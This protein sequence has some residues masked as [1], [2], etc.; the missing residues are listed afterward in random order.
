MSASLVLR[1]E[2][3]WDGCA[4]SPSSYFTTSTETFSRV[5]FGGARL[6]RRDLCLSFANGVADGFP[7]R[8]GGAGVVGQQRGKF[9]GQRGGGGHFPIQGVRLMPLSFLSCPPPSSSLPIPGEHL[10]LLRLPRA[11]LGLSLPYL[12]RHIIR[13]ILPSFFPEIFFSCVLSDGSG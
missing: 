7:I 13:I 8:A 3:A 2:F 10:V 12:R 5:P 1:Q 11:D 6:S 4:S 9:R